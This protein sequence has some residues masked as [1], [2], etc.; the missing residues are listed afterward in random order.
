MANTND[1]SGD[2]EFPLSMVQH[3]PF[4]QPAIAQEKNL[5]REITVA[6]QPIDSS[7]LPTN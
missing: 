4:F 1:L 2:D 5:K 7:G 6:Y 3:C